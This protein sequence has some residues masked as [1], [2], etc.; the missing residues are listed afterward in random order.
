[1]HSVLSV[2]SLSCHGTERR[3]GTPTL[4]D[5]QKLARLLQWCPAHICCD[6]QGNRLFSQAGTNRSVFPDC[7]I[8]LQAPS[9]ASCAGA[10][11]IW[12]LICTPSTRQADHS[13]RTL[14]ASTKDSADGAARPA[15]Q[16]LLSLRAGRATHHGTGLSST[17]TGHP[18]GQGQPSSSHF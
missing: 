17:V 13:A 18:L 7:S 9:Y 16:A 12:E 1:M 14:T 5:A 4:Q 10:P 2:G 15:F 3:R 6:W 11:G 8:L